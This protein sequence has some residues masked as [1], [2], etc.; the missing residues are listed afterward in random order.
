MKTL[1]IFWL[2]TLTVFYVYS[3]DADKQ[4]KYEELVKLSSGELIK[5]GND[6][7]EKN[8]EDTALMFYLVL[9]AKYNTQMDR[10]DQYFCALSCEKSGT[11]YSQKGNYSKAF[12]AFFKGLSICEQ[13]G[14]SDLLPGFYKNLGNMYCVFKDFDRGNANYE[15]ALALCTKQ[16]NLEIQMKILNNLAGMYC[17][18]GDTK[19]AKFYYQQMKAKSRGTSNILQ[20]YFNYLNLGL[21]YANELKRDSAMWC[22]RT[23]AEY[24]IRSKLE[25]RYKSSSYFEIAKLFEEMGEQDSALHYLNLNVKITKD[26]NLMDMLAESFKALTRIYGKKGEIN[27]EQLFRGQYQVISDSIFN[28]QELSKMKNAQFIYEMDRTRE[29]IESLN[30]E[31]TEKEL[32]IK[33]QQKILFGV[34]FGLCVFIIMSVAVYSQKRKLKLAYKDL[35]KRN[36][37]ILKSEEQSR[38]FRLEYEDKLVAE[39]ERNRELTERLKQ[40]MLYSKEDGEGLMACTKDSLSQNDESKKTYAGNK[41]TDEHKEVILQ[42]IHRVMENNEELCDCDFSLER[43]AILIGSNSRYVSQVINDTYGKNFRTYINEYRIKEAQLRLMNT[44][45]YGNYTIKAIAESV[46]YKSHANFIALFKKTTGINP[47]L[48]QKI[49][50]L[51]K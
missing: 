49:A 16:G 33:V 12:D 30:G 34:S 18:A 21:I 9:F 6:F 8:E 15:K 29:Q 1:I 13:H 44:E 36:V 22:Y 26:N 39:K 5:K 48:Y 40:M 2:L 19:K 32:K 31:K 47:Y 35:F 14:F 3:Q 11:I 50:K 4:L 27:K 37:E 20:E 45:E 23:S 43:L 10:S 41:L 28:L 46:G 38:K 7:L 51:D 25:P 42:D 17:Y 24:A